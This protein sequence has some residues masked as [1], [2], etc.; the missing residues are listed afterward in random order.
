MTKKEAFSYIK[1][2]ISMKLAQSNDLVPSD[3]GTTSGASQKIVQIGEGIPY[4]KPLSGIET[5]ALAISIPTPEKFA[6]DVIEILEKRGYPSDAKFDPSK[7][8][9]LAKLVDADLREKY[10][11]FLQCVNPEYLQ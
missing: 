9:A 5:E 11:P 6:Q 7:I 1:E 3:Q 10:E 2:K 8:D 4:F